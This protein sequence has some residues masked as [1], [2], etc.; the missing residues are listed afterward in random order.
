[1]LLQYFQSILNAAILFQNA[2]NCIIQGEK[3]RAS[4]CLPSMMTQQS[5]PPPPPSLQGILTS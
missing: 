2:A 4:L 3:E 5:L 1:M